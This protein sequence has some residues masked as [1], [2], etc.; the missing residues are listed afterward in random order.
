M[1]SPWHTCT[2]ERRSCVLGLQHEFF[3]PCVSNDDFRNHNV[4]L[5]KSFAFLNDKENLGFESQSA[6]LEREPWF[7]SQRTNLSACLMCRKAVVPE[8]SSKSETF[9]VLVAAK[10]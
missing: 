3:A 1:F 9:K 2:P 4:F 8:P 7:Y 6:S 10:A 5:N